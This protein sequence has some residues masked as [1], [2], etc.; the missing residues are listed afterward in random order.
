MA[1]R[2]RG[3]ARCP[4]CRAT[5]RSVRH[6]RQAGPPHPAR[7][8]PLSRGAA[9]YGTQCGNRLRPI[10]RRAPR[11]RRGPVPLPRRSPGIPPTAV[12]PDGGG[13]CQRPTRALVAHPRRLRPRTLLL[14]QGTALLGWRCSRP[15]RL[16][17][18][19]LRITAP[20]RTACL[21]QLPRRRH[22]VHAVLWLP[23]PLS[24]RRGGL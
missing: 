16:C 9:G 7:T 4:W 2:R 24:R 17:S 15:P 13:P 1:S 3:G 12:P 21:E 23:V 10:R 19:R 22:A 5:M 20:G 18:L 8:L 11:T 14:R 6:S